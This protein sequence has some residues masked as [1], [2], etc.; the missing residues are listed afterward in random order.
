MSYSIFG[1]P[2]LDFRPSEMLRGTMGCW[3]QECPY[4][5]YIHSTLNEPCDLSSE[6]IFKAHQEI[7][8]GFDWGQ[9]PD[10]LNDSI[11]YSL[12][13]TLKRD[14]GCDEAADRFLNS[15][16]WENF[17]ALRFAKFGAMLAK[18]N[19]N[20]GAAEQFLRVAW[21]YDDEKK[22]A[23]SNTLEKNGHRAG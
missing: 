8:S 21:F 14:N 1:Y 4:C 9:F 6:V 2:D 23:G 17:E 3:V 18:S 15:T 5:G 11:R 22:R 19:D 10:K 13:I 20:R 12:A 7:E 16:L